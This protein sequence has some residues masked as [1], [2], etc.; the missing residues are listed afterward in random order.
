MISRLVGISPSI[1]VKWNVTWKTVINN[2]I[3]VV[4]LEVI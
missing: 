1:R 2:E 4:L 3:E